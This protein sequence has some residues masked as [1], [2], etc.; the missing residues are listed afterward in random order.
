[1]TRKVALPPRKTPVERG[2]VVGGI[3]HAYASV[4]CWHGI[5]D[6]CAPPWCPHCG[7][8]CHCPCHGFRHEGREARLS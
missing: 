7:A 1:M 4:A 5:H 2:P 6:K 3:N 8:A